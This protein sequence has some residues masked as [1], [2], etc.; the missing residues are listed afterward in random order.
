MD[1]FQQYVASIEKFIDGKLKA[2]L[3]WFS[4]PEFLNMLKSRGDQVDGEV[5]DM[6][7]SLG[8]FQLFKELILDYKDEKE[9]KG[10]DLTGLLQVK[11]SKTQ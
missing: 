5:F 3:P 7:A 8:D 11:P 9:G 10:M 6:L 4:M 1:I 2:Q